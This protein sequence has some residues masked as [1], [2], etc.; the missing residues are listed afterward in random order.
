MCFMWVDLE[1]SLR[2]I[3]WYRFIKYGFTEISPLFEEKMK[4]VFELWFNLL[5]SCEVFFIKHKIF[6][7]WSDTHTHTHTHTHTNTRSQSFFKKNN[8]FWKKNL[9]LINPK[10]LESILTFNRKYDNKIMD[11]LTLIKICIWHEFFWLIVFTSDFQTF[12]RS[13]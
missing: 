6:K 7:L 13:S 3:F 11:S 1:T 4:N 8:D 10:I 2:L 9:C 12:L 5:A